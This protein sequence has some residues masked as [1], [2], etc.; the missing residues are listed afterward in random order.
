MERIRLADLHRLARL[1]AEYRFGD[2]PGELRAD[3]DA[4]H[5]LNASG[6]LYHPRN[7]AALDRRGNE[8]GIRTLPIRRLTPTTNRMPAAC[9]SFTE[10]RSVCHW[11]SA[12]TR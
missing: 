1:A 5:R 8:L 9:R 4:D 7:R 10:K 2:A 3:I 12:S 6:R 11:S